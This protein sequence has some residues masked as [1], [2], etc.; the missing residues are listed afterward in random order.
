[1]NSTRDKARLKPKRAETE[2]RC[3][4]TYVGGTAKG[5]ISFRRLLS[6]CQQRQGLLFSGDFTDYDEISRGLRT[7]STMFF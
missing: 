7:E 3:S 2:R 4:L 5:R 1:M 6:A